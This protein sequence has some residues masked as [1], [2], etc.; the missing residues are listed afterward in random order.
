M[1]L[2]VLR[3]NVMLGQP[4]RKRPVVDV[5]RDIEAVKRVCRR[6]FIEFADDNTF[7]DHAW[8]KELCRRLVPHKLNWFT[9]DRY[10][11][12]RRSGLLDLMRQSR[13]R[14]VLIGVESPENGA[15]QGIE[16]NADF[17]ARSW[18]TAVEAHSRHSGSP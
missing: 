15:L 14:Q 13:C 3:F 6:P 7:V 9:G 8:G 16:L 2:R 18:A 5:I 1:A 12:R 10:F 4:Y 11:G 17:K